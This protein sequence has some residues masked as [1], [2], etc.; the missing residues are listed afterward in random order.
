MGQF[1]DFI[2][3]FFLYAFF[4]SSFPLVVVCLWEPYKLFDGVNAT[5]ENGGVVGV[6]GLGA[7]DTDRTD[8]PKR[9]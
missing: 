6:S 3:K 8:G 7:G 2:I 1:I 5:G 9:K 4:I